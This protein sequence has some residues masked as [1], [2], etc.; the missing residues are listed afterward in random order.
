MG[1]SHENAR[2]ADDA[3]ASG[4]WTIAA[5]VLVAVAAFV[6]YWTTLLPGVDLGDSG[7]IQT[8]V[9]STL[10][11]PRNGY[12]LYFAIGGAALA[13]T[14]DSP[15]RT[16]NLVSATEAAAAC[17]LFVIVATE[18]AGSLI[19]AIGAASLFA[20]SYTF[21]SQ[22]VTAEV[23]A[24]HISFVL[25]CLWLLLRWAEKP[26]TARLA[27]FFAC[28]ALGF[29]NHLSMILL[30]PGFV[31]FLFLSE[32]NG[33]RAMF[34][35][36]VIALAVGLALLGACQYLWNVR[37]LWFLPQPPQSIGEAVRTFWFDV[38][39]SDW[40]E[41]M[42]MNVPES[43]LK[44]HLAMYWFDLRQ[45]FGIAAIALAVAGAVA[46]AR[47]HPRRALLLALLYLVNAAFAFGYNVG[48][49]HVFYLP[50]HLIVALLAGI[51]AASIPLFVNSSRRWLATAASI[52]LL[53]YAVARGYEDFPALDRSHDERA[54]TALDR[55]TADL[56]DRRSIFV[57]DL[58]WQLANGLSYYSSVATP[59][60]AVVRAR[61]VLLY[62]PALIES[63]ETAGRRI[64]T[65]AA[66]TRL[67]NA[68]YGPLLHTSPSEPTPTLIDVIRRLAPGT[69]YALAILKPT[70]DF[71][72]DRDE[73]RESLAVL[74]GGAA[75]SV[76]TSDYAAILGSVGRAPDF[77]QQAPYPFTGRFSAQGSS[78]QVRMES[79]LSADT[80]RR[81]GFGHIIVNRQHTLIVER[82][83]SFATFDDAGTPTQTAY[84]AGLF[85]P[86][87]RDLVSLR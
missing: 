23:Y 22:S 58:N 70:R 20:V 67:L 76:P 8:T 52:V 34:R 38:T 66:A 55:L 18:L 49:T 82:G 26:T 42:V 25:A 46:I 45:Q 31:A 47:R 72:L 74:S 50:S 6:L 51:G 68:A 43:L 64:V 5:A 3:H 2:G 53:A 12:P 73:L 33:W 16:M 14:H 86:I 35:P 59:Q 15:A 69:R 87:E 75:V 65:N 36:R 17:G 84:F 4:R 54:A 32:P 78:I 10:L 21:W 81:M 7:S 11:T 71:T 39:K 57:V 37:T 1:T 85:A 40:R 28:Y 41:T 30:A 29:G 19:A 80:I 56:D 83:V 60:V 48:D 62:A 77:V 44:D 27:A 61:D 63:N 13:I 79:W 24:L 9:G